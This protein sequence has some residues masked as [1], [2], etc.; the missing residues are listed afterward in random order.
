M[1]AKEK[2]NTG[3]ENLKNGFNGAIALGAA[4]GAY[5]FINAENKKRKQKQR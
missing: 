1:T 3:M 2:F 5:A 4:A